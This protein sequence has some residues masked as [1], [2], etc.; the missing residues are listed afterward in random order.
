MGVSGDGSQLIGLL[1]ALLIE[2]TIKEQLTPEQEPKT[3]GSKYDPH[4][5][6]N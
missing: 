1:T 5:G 2:R 4:H 6:P 3:I